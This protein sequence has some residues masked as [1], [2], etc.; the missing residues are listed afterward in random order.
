M[1]TNWLTSPHHRAWL[2]QHVRGLL[3]F[4]RRTGRVG[5]GAHWLDDDGNPD[6]TRPQHAWITT[7]TVHVYGLGALLGV[8]GSRPIAETA[9]AA[10]LDGGDLHD[11]VNDGWYTAVGDGRPVT[12]KSCY[13]H[14]FVI[15]AG[16]TASHVG[17]PGGRELYERASDVF[18][19]RFW[20]DDAGRCV[21]TWDETFTELDPYRGLNA[22]MHA[23]EAMLSAASLTGEPEWLDRAER[24]SRFVID[25]ASANHWRIPEH[26][27]DRWQP[28]LGFNRDRPADQFKPY[29]S[30]VGHSFEWSRLLLHLANAPIGT[31]RPGLV[32]AASELFRQATADGWAPDGAPGFVYTVD[33]DGSPVVRDRLWWVLAEAIAAAA[34]LHRQ[35]GDPSYAEQYRRWWDHAAV[36]H[37]EPDNGSWRHQLDADNQPDTTV[38]DGKPDLY[39]VVQ[40]T[41]LPTQPAWPMVAAALDRPG[42]RPGPFTI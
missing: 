13:D 4:G 25:Q 3:A 20:D 18:L 14:V 10:L 1:T 5:G 19:E 7:R 11:D 6:P 36:H 28:D 42:R 37:I 9:L 32:T 30:T 39:H 33:W 41:L 17:L 26:Y 35:T 38:W 8:P 23:V 34:V 12:D 2:D 24:V 40:A 15:L 16:A 27:D 21:D 22:N 31:D 29:G